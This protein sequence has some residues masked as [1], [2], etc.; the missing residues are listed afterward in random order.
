MALAVAEAAD[1]VFTNCHQVTEKPA[2]EI[3]NPHMP[4]KKP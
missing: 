1:C 3:A 2:I 4:T